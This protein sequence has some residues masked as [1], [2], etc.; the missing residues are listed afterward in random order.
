MALEKQLESTRITR[1]GDPYP[2]VTPLSLKVL[3]PI[4]PTQSCS[5]NF[6][7]RIKRTVGRSLRGTHCKRNLVPSRKQVTYKL[8]GIKSCLLGPK[9]VPRPL[10]G[11]NCPCSDRQHPSGKQGRKHKVGLTLCSFVENSNLVFQETGY[12]QSLTHSRLSECNSRQTIQARPDH[13]DKVV[14]PSRGLPVNMHQ[15]APTDS[16]CVTSSRPP[17]LGSR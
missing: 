9:R 3:A 7:R 11:Q 2:K 6:Y 13:S 1:K 12:S 16:V 14:S 10:L 5:A 8:S 4:I 15:V 17:G